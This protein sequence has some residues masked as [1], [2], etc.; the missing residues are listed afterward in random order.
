VSLAGTSIRNSIPTANQ[1]WSRTCFA[2]ALMDKGGWRRGRRSG[3][4]DSAR[5]TYLI[6]GFIPTTTL[7][8]L[9]W[10]WRGRNPRNRRHRLKT[11]AGRGGNR[12]EPVKQRGVTSLGRPSISQARPSNQVCPVFCEARTGTIGSDGIVVPAGTYRLTIEDSNPL[13]LGEIEI[14][15]GARKTVR[16]VRA[17]DGL[18]RSAEL[19]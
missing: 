6:G 1:F 4:E 12:E 7:P 2:E 17:A 11:A 19:E 18:R 3:E 13:D 16:L 8:A 9:T 10:P 14:A 15:P 5:T